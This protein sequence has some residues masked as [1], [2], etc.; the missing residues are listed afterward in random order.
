MEDSMTQDH[1]FASGEGNNWYRRNL[2]ALGDKDKIDWPLFVFDLIGN[3]DVI[4]SVIEL[5]CCNGFRLDRLKREYLPQAR[6]VGIDASGEAIAAGA[7]QY[8]A[9]E[10]HQGKLDDP[11][12]QEQFDLVII[13]YVLHWVD[14]STLT[15]S[16][17]AV[18]RFV[19]DGGFLL[20]GDFLPDYPQR[21]R[22][23]HLPEQNVFTYKQNYAAIFLSLGLYR[24]MAHFTYDHD[25]RSSYALQPAHSAGRGVCSLLHKSLEGFYPEIAP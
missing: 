24:E 18:D 11:Y 5:G 21:R 16:I 22:Y 2:E 8:P 1:L 4:N 10:L 7:S 14:R 25:A 12:V 17:A 15:Q 23:H 20:L 19:K 6:C 13:N 9:L 3:K